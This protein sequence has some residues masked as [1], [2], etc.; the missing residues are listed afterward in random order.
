[1]KKVDWA[2]VLEQIDVTKD[3]YFDYGKCGIVNLYFNQDCI[4]NERFG[5]FVN[6]WYSRD[7]VIRAYNYTDTTDDFFEDLDNN[8]AVD[9]TDLYYETEEDINWAIND[10]NKTGDNIKVVKLECGAR[11]DAL[12]EWMYERMLAA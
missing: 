4:D 8:A 5:Q 2:K 9:I 12:M 3:I 11:D 10:F 6:S 7:D 1:M